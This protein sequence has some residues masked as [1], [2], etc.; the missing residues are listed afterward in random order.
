MLPATNEMS[1]DGEFLI[2]MDVWMGLYVLA[3]INVD[4][5]KNASRSPHGWVDD[6]R[7]FAQYLSDHLP[8]ELRMPVPTRRA[9]ALQEG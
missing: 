9:L 6:V 5:R 1:K 3:L 4:L 2:A 8:E 7:A